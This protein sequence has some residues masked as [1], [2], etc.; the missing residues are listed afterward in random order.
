MFSRALSRA[1]GY[2]WASLANVRPNSTAVPAPIPEDAPSWVDRPERDLVNFPR[3]VCPVDPHPV[4]LGFIPQTWFDM[5]YNQTG[6]TGPYMLG[7]GMMTF[8][9][10]KEIF[11]LEHEFA[12]GCVIFSVYAC[13]IKKF[14]PGFAESLAKQSEEENASLDALQGA[15]MAVDQEVID[16]ATACIEAAGGNAHLFT[17]KRENVALQLEAG[18]RQRIEDVHQAVKKRL[19]YQL[20]TA[21]VEQRFEQKHMVKWIVDNVMKSIT[22]AQEKAALA[23]C[24]ADLKGMVPAKA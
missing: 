15:K 19:D 10:S 2:K 22:P 21:N 16:E 13:L 11:V 14:G 9:V 12:S 23:Q 4:R 1:G 17:A 7:V 24:I 18:Y 8:L 20:E 6:V 3:P 5:F